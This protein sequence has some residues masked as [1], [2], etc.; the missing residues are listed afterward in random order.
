[1]TD[2][3]HDRLFKS[4]FL[5][6]P[7]AAEA[8]RAALPPEIAARIEFS[9]LQI[10]PGSFVDQSN[11]QYH[12]DLLYSIQYAGRTAYIYCLYEHQSS[13]DWWMALRMLTYEVNIY[14][15]FRR[16]NDRARR[17]PF[18]FPL[19]FHHGRAPWSTSTRIEDLIDLPDDFP[20][21]LRALVPHFGFALDDLP[22]T[23]DA[24]I[25]ARATSASVELV[26]L[27]FKHAR[28]ADHLS[29]LLRDWVGLLAAVQREESGTRAMRLVFEYLLQ[30]RGSDERGVLD[31][32]ATELEKGPLA[33]MQTIADWLEERGHTAGLQQGLQTGLQQG[34]RNLLLRLLA[35]RFGELP[36]PVVARVEA[37]DETMLTHWAELLLTA[38]NL[39]AVFAG[40]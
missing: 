2:T 5:H 38:D 26:L 7:W 18:I 9:T 6:L 8:L 35:R 13:D 24:A 30:V 20:T 33:D 37:A 16:D 3:P 17:L 36:A 10:M 40:E 27:A 21:A 12:T 11:R 39:G 25:H 23:T 15:A 28:T 4:T 14:A 22:A 34:Q 1:M 32:V 29:R 19:V 31:V